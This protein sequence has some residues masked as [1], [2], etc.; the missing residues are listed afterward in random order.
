MMLKEHSLEMRGMPHQDLEDYFLSIGG[1]QVGPG[2]YLCSDWKVEL[3]NESYCTLGSLRVPVTFVTFQV[4]EEEWP[5][6]VKAFR[7]RFLSAGG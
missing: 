7:L 3:S 4:N 5:S 2:M 6:I 1:K